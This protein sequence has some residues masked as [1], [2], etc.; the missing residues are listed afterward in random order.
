MTKSADSF[1]HIF[2]KKS[3]MESLIFS[4]VAA[5]HGTDSGIKDSFNA[6]T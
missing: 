2:L 1:G 5:L 4:A 6:G 3:L